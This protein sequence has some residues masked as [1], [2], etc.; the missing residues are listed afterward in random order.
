MPQT[1][2][3]Q[4]LNEWTERDL[5]KAARAGDLAPAFEVDEPLRRVIDVLASGRHPVLCGESGVGKSAIVNELA[6]RW[7]AGSGP[8]ALAGKRILQI[9]LR[10]RAS[11]MLRPEQ[12]RPAMQKLVEALVASSD[13]VVPFFRDLHVAYEYDL[14]PQLQSLAMRLRGPILG[15]A[16]P[17]TFDRMLEATPGL[18]QF[19][20]G[21]PIQEPDLERME[22]I[23]ALWADAHRAHGHVFTPEALRRATELAHRFLARARMPRK[24][25][26]F[27]A[28]VESVT[29][30]G[31]PVLDS[32]VIERFYEAYKVPRLL[33]D[34][35]VSFDAEATLR[36]FRARVLGQVEAVRTVVRM[37]SLI[38]SGLS[39]TRRP[40]GTF[41][42]VGPTGVGKTHVAQILAEYLFG[43]PDRVI[44]LNMGDF[45][46]PDASDTLFGNP[47]AHLPRLRRGLLT[48][49][50]GGHPF[51]VLLLDEFEKS[52]ATVHDRFLQLFD[53]GA[54]INGEG[55]TVSCRSMII[56]ATSNAGAEVYR[57]R[58]LGF[59]DPP[60]VQEMDLDL[61]RMLHR[62][63]RFELL[64]RFDEIVRF[65]P[66]SREDIR[67]IALREIEALRERAGLKQRGLMLEIDEGILD[68]L[69]A[70]GYDP[71]FGARFL[72]RTIERNLTTALAEA[73]VRQPIEAGTRVALRVRGAQIVAVLVEEPVEAPQVVRLPEGTRQ[74]A[75]TLDRRALVDR[76]RALLDATA[77]YLTRLQQHKD[78]ANS[79]LSAMTGERF[80][81]EAADAQRI[82]ERYR[83]ADV[84]VQAEV[85]LAEPIQRL[86]DMI[87]GPGSSGIKAEWIAQ[88]LERASGALADWEDRAAE[89]G[90]GAVWL[91]LRNFDPLVPAAEWIEELAAM[92]LAWCGRLGLAAEVVAVGFSEE[93]LARAVVEV[94][95]PGAHTYLDMERGV[96]RLHRERGDVRVR[97]DAVSRG[98][99]GPG[100]FRTAPVQRR[101]GALGVDIAYVGRVERLAAG[102]NLELGGPARGCLES[103]LADLDR[104]SEDLVASVHVARIYAQG[105]SGAR[106]PRSGA[107]VPRFKDAM[108]GSLDPLLEGWRRMRRAAAQPVEVER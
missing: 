14:E 36:A 32:A 3:T 68:W 87:D 62:Q 10:T 96:H 12:M 21:L 102:L 29:A 72:R 45:G 104:A 60:D 38:K 92:Y 44:R 75:V 103:L 90:S 33:I 30:P 8:S 54:L 99:D 94:E 51:G 2:A 39:D 79:L 88:A 59:G 82:L 27:L 58:P 61:N 86:A 48:H 49:R 25:M 63:F 97:V 34:P 70:H 76:A 46:D 55:E 53:E 13:A 35:H 81:D 11:A 41:L 7:E 85:R 50:L 37:I 20:V 23:L 40:F 26:D 89:E 67:T 106:D 66:L 47:N 31:Q 78:E 108:R 52:H 65:R 6:R 43:S 22:R 1:G 16:H 84:T 95:G 77:P 105:G 80:W 18:E 28:T 71:L 15:E 107:V 4:V 98:G 69:T 91:V 100:G 5:T 42:F 73:I 74:K 56:I 93:K 101:A 24:V 64:N 57:G 19:Y 9:S 83:R 17:Q